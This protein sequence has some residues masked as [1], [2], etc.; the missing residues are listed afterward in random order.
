MLEH[1]D[2]VN[3]IDQVDAVENDVEAHAVDRA[4]EKPEIDALDEND[5]QAHIVD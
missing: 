3:G 4:A 1:H 2:T 5:V